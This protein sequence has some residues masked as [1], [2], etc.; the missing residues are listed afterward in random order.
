MRL[1]P[2]C[3]VIQII[4]TVRLVPATNGFSSNFLP[5]CTLSRFDTRG[6]T[7]LVAVRPPF[8]ARQRTQHPRRGRNTHRLGGGQRQC[9]SAGGSRR[10]QR[11]SACRGG[12]PWRR[13]TGRAG[14]HRRRGTAL[15]T[16]GTRGAVQGGTGRPVQRGHPPMGTPPPGAW[17]GRGQP[18]GL[19]VCM[20]IFI[21]LYLYRNLYVNIFI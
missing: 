11:R 6:L 2:S 16:R 3:V 9:G 5:R 12:P 15:G 1:H 4:G 21:Y 13:H 17:S 14:G 7:P 8:P 18:Y 19:P 20:L 10:G